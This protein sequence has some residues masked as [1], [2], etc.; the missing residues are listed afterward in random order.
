MKTI[1]EVRVRCVVD[2]DG[3]WIWQGAHRTCKGSAASY[4]AIYA[5]NFTTDPSGPMSVQAGKRAVWHMVTGVAIPA[6][7]E[8]F[9]KC[10]KPGCVKPGCL[11]CDVRTKRGQSM[12]RSGVLT[13]KNN[14][15]MAAG[16][17]LVTE[18]ARVDRGQSKETIDAIFAMAPTMTQR[19]IGE[20]VGMRKDSIG[21]ILRG[22][23]GTHR[24]LTGN[25]WAGLV[26]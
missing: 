18:K 8:A 20:V 26:T 15:R 24:R 16:H 7:H 12:S 5:P 21:R 4:P 3:C 25:P 23:I 2:D 9:T 1:K 11:Q 13:H 6:G 19:A 14:V 22:E 17:K 10:H